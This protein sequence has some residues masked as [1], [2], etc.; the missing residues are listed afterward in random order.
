M[1]WNLFIPQEF[2]TWPDLKKEED[3]DIYVPSSSW[4]ISVTTSFRNLIVII[5]LFD[6]YVA[7]LYLFSH[8]ASQYSWKTG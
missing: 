3:G 2:E 4:E 6:A 5:H 1:E 7:F 8:H